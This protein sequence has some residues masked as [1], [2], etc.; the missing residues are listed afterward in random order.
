M[1]I[2]TLRILLANKET[3]LYKFM[4]LFQQQDSLLLKH[5][6]TITQQARNFHTITRKKKG[7][8]GF[9]GAKETVQI[10]ISSK[11][12]HSTSVPLKLGRIKN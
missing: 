4:G 1:Q 5:L 9:F 6:P 10:P 11:T 3:H 12:V 7:I 8:A 2:D